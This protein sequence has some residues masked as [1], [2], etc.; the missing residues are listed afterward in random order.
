MCVC[1][2]GGGG[3]GGVQEERMYFMDGPLSI[4]LYCHKR[5]ADAVTNL[6]A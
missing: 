4:M 6:L 2:W 3:G 5:I 1:V